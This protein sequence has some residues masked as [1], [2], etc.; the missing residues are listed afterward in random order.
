M[1]TLIVI[2]HVDKIPFKECYEIGT[3]YIYLL[4]KGPQACRNH[5]KNIRKSEQKGD[6]M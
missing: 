1:K 6:I 2:N 5:E 3:L 4:P